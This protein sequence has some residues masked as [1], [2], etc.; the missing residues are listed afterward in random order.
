MSNKVEISERD[1][2]CLFL[3]GL[4]RG[5]FRCEEEPEKERDDQQ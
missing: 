2:S 4:F 3:S 5:G 1:E